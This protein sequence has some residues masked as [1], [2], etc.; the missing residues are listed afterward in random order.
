MKTIAIDILKARKVHNLIS[1]DV[2]EIDGNDQDL[3]NDVVIGF[4]KSHATSIDHLHMHV[5]IMPFDSAC[6]GYLKYRNSINF[7]TIDSVID[8]LKK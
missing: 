5:I 8:R 1:K 6:I 7:E 3:L 4:H 2:Y